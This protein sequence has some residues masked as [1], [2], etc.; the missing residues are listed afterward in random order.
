VGA[1]G[2]RPAALL[3]AALLAAATALF[4]L[5]GPEQQ[6]LS[7]T[8]DDAYYY[9]QIARNAAHGRGISFDGLAPTNGFHPLYF[10][11]LVFLGHLRTGDLYRV[12]RETIR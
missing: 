2:R 9:F 8:N 12:P 6:V 3:V 1:P 10:A 7:L 11:V 4:L 5:T